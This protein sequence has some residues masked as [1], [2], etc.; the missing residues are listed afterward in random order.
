MGNEKQ[1]QNTI[2][3]YF[4]AIFSVLMCIGVSVVL[5]Q[6][7]DPSQNNLKALSSVCMD[8]VCII[9]LFI[10]LSSFSFTNYGANKTTKRYVGL[11]SATV[12]ALFLDFLNWVFDGTL[13]F[14]HLTFWFTL[15]SLCMGSILVLFFCWYLCSYLEE[16][17]NLKNM[18]IKAKVCSVI[19]LF[20]F[21]MTFIFAI[22]GTAFRFVDGHYEIGALY[23]VITIIPVLTMF[24]MVGLVI[25]HVRTIGWHDVIAVTGY[26]LF[27]LA[28]AFIEA[29][30]SIGTTYVADAIANIFIFVM[31]QNEV[32]AR[33][34]QQMIRWG[35]L[36]ETNFLQVLPV[37]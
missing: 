11:L 13:E 6:F 31:L 12:W 14:G 23:D 25:R 3:K 9:I 24:Y 21:V 20:S 2:Y 36:Q 22:T 5:T 18:Q 32:I 19:N 30:Y 16:S 33:E 29:S 28:G 10:L 7:Y 4:L 35:I 17:H 34:K 1:K 8:I 26:I 15:G 27:A 37:V